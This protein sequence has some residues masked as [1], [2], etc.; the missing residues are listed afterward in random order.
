M[1]SQF[2]GID[3][4]GS[5]ITSLPLRREGG[6]MVPAGITATT[7]VDA[8]LDRESL[9]QAWIGHLKQQEVHASG[10][11]AIAMPGPFEYASGT[12]R[13]KPG[14]KMGALNGLDLRATLL[15]ELPQL[16]A[17]YFENDA[18]CFGLGADQKFRSA[19]HRR[20]MTITLGTGIGSAFVEDG[21]LVKA[22]PGLPPGGEIYQ[23]PFGE[24]IADDFF[25][26]RWFTHFAE[27]EFGIIVPDLLALIGAATPAELEEIF[28]AYASNLLELL[29]PVC[30]KFRPETLVLGG[31]I[32]RA[33]PRFAPAFAPELE[34]MGVH[35]YAVPQEAEMLTCLGAGQII[36]V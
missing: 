24:G 34:K 31:N 1:T 20:L 35:I 29:L 7:K 36:P 26:T 12:A 4:G 33:Y 3:I 8:F 17:V 11:I 28:A 15:R 5:H 6:K 22:M 9:L 10:A 18:A 2:L 32:A 14:L 13:F 25:G 16:R 21:R 30:R 27:T 23:V 19:G